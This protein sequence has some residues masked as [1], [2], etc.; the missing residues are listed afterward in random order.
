M[1]HPLSTMA[2]WFAA[3]PM[4]EH[5]GAREGVGGNAEA[6]Q[7]ALLTPFQGSGLGP[8]GRIGIRYLIVIIQ[9]EQ[10]QNKAL[11]QCFNRICALCQSAR[12][13]VDRVARLRDPD[14]LRRTGHPGSTPPPKTVKHPAGTYPSHGAPATAPAELPRLRLRSQGRCRRTAH[15]FFQGLQ[16]AG[17]EVVGGCDPNYSLRFGEA[18]VSLLEFGAR[19]VLVVRALQE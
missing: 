18:C 19:S 5:Q 1:A 9:S 3:T 4:G 10:K 7:K 2:A 16:R 8:N 13:G 14:S 11:H 17:E 15:R 12:Y 6:G